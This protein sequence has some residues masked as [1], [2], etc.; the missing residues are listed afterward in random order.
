MAQ[1][2][3]TSIN[4]NQNELQNARIQNLSGNP[5]N[6]V[7]GQIY[8]HNTQNTIFYYDGTSWH[9]VGGDIRQ[10]TAGTGLDLNGGDGLSGN[11]TIKLSDTA[12]TAGS[13]GS[14]TAIPVFTVNQQGQ[15]TAASTASVATDLTIDADGAT[16][17]DVSLLS[18]DLQILGD[19]GITTSV[20]K[21]GTDVTVQIDLDDTAVTAGSYGLAGSIPQFTV[22]AQG[23]IT[24]AS[25]VTIDI[26]STQINDF[27]EAVQ[28]VVGAFVVGTTDEVDVAYDDNAGTFT[29]GLTSTAVTNGSYGSATQIPTFTVDT[30]GRLTAAA[31]V[32]ISIP[33]T[34][35][36]D[37]T[38]AVQ[39]VVGAFVQ[40]TANEVTVAYDDNAG[41]F[42]IGLPDDVTIGQNLT[43]TGNLTVN[44]TTTTVNSTTVTLDDPIFTLGGDVAPTVD[45]DKDRG[46]EFRWHDGTDA[47]V[48]FFGF[49]DSTGRFTFVPE[50]TNA[51]EV[52]SGTL[53]GVDVG[54]LWVEGTQV[55]S[56]SVDLPVA[57]GGT[58][59]STELDARTNLGVKTNA[60]TPNTSTSVLARIASKGC[61]ASTGSPAVSTTT[62]DHQFGTRNVI[63]QIYDN[64]S[65]EPTYGDTVHG[66][67][68]RSS[69]DEVTVTLNGTMSADDYMIVVTAA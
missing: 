30:Q 56:S 52:F 42:T 12:V 23:R 51:S 66:D 61:A 34:Q 69:D 2:F 53:G 14:G 48:G 18:D 41:T 35:V 11:V 38:E 6:P 22:D 36:N 28:D 9:D 68:R 17:A 29:I 32:S 19:T 65:A 46:I 40:G 43:I 59:A 64:R 44:G 16:T 3:L 55:L 5:S 8:F 33:S 58:G 27:T 37:F 25:N 26:P 67:V 24:G 60:G 50:A 10:I 31:D 20:S 15:I 1:T 7:K 21:N 39:D 54:S 49:D 45:D 47:K 57:Y 13:Y 62:V 4:L 63:V